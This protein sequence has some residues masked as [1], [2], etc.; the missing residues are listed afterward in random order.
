MSL[1]SLVPLPP[2][3]HLADDEEGDLV[4]DEK[5][6]EHADGHGLFLVVKLGATRSQGTSW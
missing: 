6:N 5:D 3:M 2:F 1:E 4:D